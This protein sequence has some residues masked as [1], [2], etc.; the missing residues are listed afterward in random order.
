ML[1]QK[2]RRKIYQI[3]NWAIFSI[4][5]PA[6]KFK[7]IAGFLTTMR[8]RFSSLINMLPARCITVVFCVCTI[9]NHE[10]LSIFKQ[11]TARPKTIPL[12]AIN[13]IESF[14]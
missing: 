7:A 9:A 13:L 12:I 4:C 14:L 5:P 3:G 2:G 11:P 6:G 1:G 10:Q 8:I